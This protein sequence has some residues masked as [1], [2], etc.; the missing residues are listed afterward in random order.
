[1]NM[2]EEAKLFLTP[3][4]NN[5]NEQLDKPFIT[6]TYAQSI[7]SKIALKG[8]QLILSGKES[9]IMTHCLRVLNDAI[10]VGGGTACV[11]NPQLNARFLP[12]DETYQQ[13]QPII[14]D[15]KL[16]LPLNCRL[17]KNHQ[18]GHGKQPWIMTSIEMESSTKKLELEKAGAKIFMIE[19]I[20]E[21]GRLEWGK[22]WKLLK[23]LGIK[24]VMVE[25][26]SRIIQ[27]CLSSGL[28]DL[29]IVTIAPIYVGHEGVD[30]SAVAK[31]KDVH[32]QSFGHDM[33]L[34]AKII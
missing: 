32:Y 17:L 29:L 4:Y 33:V 18:Q 14:L 30:V 26:G 27:S 15:T 10:L 6:L 20:K 9:L 22:V 19:P 16:E 12:E 13:P 8:K 5:I 28:V 34:A 24:N 7:D 23:E 11:D 1:M 21:T 3:L 2:Y 25:G 31:L